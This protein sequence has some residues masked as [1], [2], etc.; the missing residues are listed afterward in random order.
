MTD[1]KTLHSFVALGVTLALALAPAFAQKQGLSAH[2]GYVD[3]SFLSDLVPDDLEGVEVVEINIAGPLL[4]ALS[5]MLNSE[6]ENLG[7]VVNQLRG[8]TAVVASGL[9]EA[10]SAKART[11]VS[12]ISAKLQREGWERLVRVREKGARTF[13]FLHYDGEAVDGLTVLSYEDDEV[14]FVNIAGT[15][16]L[17]TLSELG[18]SMDLPGLDEAVDAVER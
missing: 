14:T 5:P 10:T 2:P 15:I 6:D 17:A 18:D 1:R 7:A 9:D 16:D 3:G 11:F 12:E 13:V 8:I 4:A